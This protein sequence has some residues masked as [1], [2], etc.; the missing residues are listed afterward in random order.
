VVRLPEVLWWVDRFVVDHAPFLA[1]E[2]DRDP[3]VFGGDRH[4]G[5]VSGLAK[6]PVA[7]VLAACRCTSECTNFIGRLG[8]GRRVSK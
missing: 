4:D 7:V 3:V 8:V 2:P 5:V 1:L 6:P